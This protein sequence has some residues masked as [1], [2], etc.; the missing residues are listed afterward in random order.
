MR[1]LVGLDLNDAP[2][3]ALTVL[4]PWVDR[5]GVPAT[6][7]YA[8]GLVPLAPFLPPGEA[9]EVSARVAALK[10]LEATLPEARRGGVAVLH[11][12]AAGALAVASAGYD[13]AMVGTHGRTGISRLLQGSVAELVVRWSTAPVLV[14]KRA[15][16]TVLRALVAVDLNDRGAAVA[17]QVQPWLARLGASIELLFVQETPL[18]AG[19]EVS[20]GHW[21]RAL[22]HRRIEY[23][24]AL[25]LLGDHLAPV[26]VLN[27]D[28]AL[29]SPA[30]VILERAVEYDL[31]VMGTH[32][33]TGLE[34]AWVGSVAEQVVRRSPCSVLLVHV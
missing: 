19:D 1:T 20:M 23:G 13:L 9:A 2:E 15:P 31:V 34:R 10:A 5:L 28:V 22:E 8:D 14:A 4:G 21:T 18:F 29:G 12:S 24:A 7:A 27:T 16:S 32:G 6:L 11:G 33:R 30:S 3:E 26:T 25:R 17:A